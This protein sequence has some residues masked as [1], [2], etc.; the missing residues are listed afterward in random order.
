MADVLDRPV[1][2]PVTRLHAFLSAHLPTVSIAV[3]LLAV[4]ALFSFTAET[5]LSWDNALN[6]LRQTSP[7]LIVAVA[8]TFVVATAG[9]D[10]SVGSVMALSGVLL[11]VL[12]SYGVEPGLAL[13]TV[14]AV[15]AV[16][17]FV[18]GWCSCYQR[19]PSFIVTLA[20]LGIIRGIA[21]RAT[22]GYSIALSDDGWVGFLGHGRVAGIPVQALIAGVVTVAGWVAF[23]MTPFGR[24]MVALG[25]QRE[26]L[27][28][29][30]VNVRLVGALGFV[31]AGSAAA[32]AGTLMALRLDSGSANQGVGFEL[33]V[34]TAVVLGGTS[35]FGGRGSVT[36]TVLAVLTLGL[37]ENGLSLAHVNPFYVQIVQGAI[38]LGAVVINAKL[39]GQIFL[40]R[41]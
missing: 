6:V 20:T 29:A 41:S 9:I 1:A 15:G 18:N 39:F 14:V 28:R 16:I 31:L 38:L 21:L 8:M 10:L 32:L 37:I 7:A 30:G 12:V 40:Q 27:R 11:A 35:L 5:F 23:H 19:I 25:S 4:V 3:V 24:Y 26:S 22:N 13:V 17:G 36:G 34:I 33:T 2:A